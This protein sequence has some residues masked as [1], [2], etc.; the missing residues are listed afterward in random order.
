MIAFITHEL[1]NP[2][3]DNRLF[4]FQIVAAFMHFTMAFWADKDL[5]AFIDFFGRHLSEKS[6]TNIAMRLEDFFV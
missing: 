3:I 1:S 2:I 5:K 6:E 4:S